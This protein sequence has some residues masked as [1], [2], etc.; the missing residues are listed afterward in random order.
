[1]EATKAQYTTNAGRSSQEKALC[2]SVC[3]TRSLW[4]NGRQIIK[5]DHLA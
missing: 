4:Q 2:L 5:Q 1:M 3:Q